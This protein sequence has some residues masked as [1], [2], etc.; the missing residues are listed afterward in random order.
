MRSFNTGPAGTFMMIVGLLLAVSSVY[1]AFTQSRWPALLP[2]IL[3]GLAL[4]AVGYSLVARARRAR[5]RSDGSDG[6][7]FQGPGT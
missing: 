5:S 4:T 2:S 6:D 1:T 3:I 7:E